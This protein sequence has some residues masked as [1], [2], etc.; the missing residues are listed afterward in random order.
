MKF[1]KQS[2]QLKILTVCAALLAAALRA[3]HYAFGMDGRN[4]LVANHWS[5]LGL[6]VVSIGFALLLLLCGRTIK[7][8]E[9]C[10]D[11]FPTSPGAAVGCFVLAAGIVLTSLQQSGAFE[12]TA[13][14]I[15]WAS[16]FLAAAGLLVIGIC[17]LIGK[18]PRFLF[19][20]VLCLFFTLRMIAQYRHWSADPQLQDYGFYLCAHVAVMLAA[21]HHAALD[22]GVGKRRALWICSLSAVYLCCAAV[23]HCS[24]A[25]LMGTSALWALSNLPDL[26]VQHR[27]SRPAFRSAKEAEE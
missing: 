8:T 4:L 25:L 11:D 20:A 12:L 26:P 23:P 5:V 18:K 10:A 16:G 13:D 22:V 24:E 6:W 21:Y 14:K 7:G 19:H 1:N 2:F 27:R 17:R 15:V 9:A 3:A